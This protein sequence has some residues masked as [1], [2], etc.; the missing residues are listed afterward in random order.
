M[1]VSGLLS[2]FYFSTRLIISRRIP[3]SKRRSF[4]CWRWVLLS[5]LHYFYLQT[6]F[7]VLHILTNIG[8][9]LIA[10][11]SLASLRLYTHPPIPT[12]PPK[13]SSPIT[14]FKA[15]ERRELN[16]HNS[17]IRAWILNVS[18]SMKPPD[19]LDNKIQ[20]NTCRKNPCAVRNNWKPPRT[21]HCS[22][23][24]ACR[25]GFDHHCPWVNVNFFL[26]YVLPN[27]CAF[28]LALASQQ[29]SFHVSP[30]SSHASHSSPYFRWPHSS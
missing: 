9:L 23:C 4:R 14:P 15:P 22:S 16:S 7:T 10:L 28:R 18:S 17:H 6:S 21:H 13:L 2:C 8:L 5:L 3:C 24:A 11:A 30:S 26:V 19:K 20:F 12:Q 27:I 1:D 25:V 29:T